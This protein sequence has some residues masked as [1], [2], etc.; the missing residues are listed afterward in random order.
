MVI[1]S[2][3]RPLMA[4]AIALVAVGCGRGPVPPEL[5][6]LGPVDPAVHALLADLTARVERARSDHDAWGRLGMALEAN[7][8]LVEAERVY[9]TAMASAGHEPR[10]LYRRAILRA[11]RGEVSEALDD[12]D[13]VI[14]LAPGYV[15]ARWRQGLWRLDLGDMAAAETSLRAAIRMAPD[16]PAGHV[17][18]ALVHLAR[19]DD[20]EAVKTLEALLGARP[21]H[22][23]A[24][25]LLGTAYRRLGRDDEARFA[26]AVGSMGEPEWVD[27]WSDEVAQYRRGFAAL[28]KEATALGL[29]QR[30]DE[31]ITLLQRLLAER[32]DDTALRVYLG[33][34]YASARRME[35]AEALLLPVLAA[36]P[37]SFDAHMHLAAGY[38]FV[39][40]L[41]RAATH[42]GRAVALRPSSPEAARLQGV[43]RWQQGRAD[44]AAQ[45]FE[46]AAL[47][48][49]RDPMPHL[50]IGMILGE[51]GQYLAAR[52][53]FELALERNPL[54][55]DALIGVA[56]TYAAL[57]D[58]DQ[59]ERIIARAV[60]ADPHNPRL[61]AA[62]AR[63]GSAARARQ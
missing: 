54:L 4:L 52:R 63:I 55:G 8:L 57:G 3:R 31:A 61:P 23:Y 15:P 56:D 6:S 59:A 28:L 16:D 7:G 10:W 44:E 12:L 39:H 46:T 26:L 1:A 19:R 40:A 62:R 58:F 25:H 36:D 29:E 35:D 9:E 30:Y 22:R 50:W 20:A 49:P 27:P 43:V 47:E 42:A 53:R 14:R 45:L 32:P 24:L 37:G 18:L 48:N 38:L 5:T 11:R 17:G 34:M 51:R 21:G 13:R 41:D 60:Q 33:G 2:G